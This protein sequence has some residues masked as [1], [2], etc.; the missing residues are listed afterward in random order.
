MISPRCD[1][2]MTKFK[3]TCMRGVYMVKG[4]T[5]SCASYLQSS[6]LIT[7]QFHSNKQ[8]KQ[9]PRVT[10]GSKGAENEK[11]P[12]IF[13][14]RQHGCLHGELVSFK[15]L[16]IGVQ[17]HQT[18]YLLFVYARRICLLQF[19]ISFYVCNCAT[20]VFNPPTKVVSMT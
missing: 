14:Y 13:Q 15:T 9:R 3:I 16:D 1:E 8:S 17:T 10:F 2:L 18:T 11:A 19:V 12:E 6:S 5:N 7:I 20:K 4:I